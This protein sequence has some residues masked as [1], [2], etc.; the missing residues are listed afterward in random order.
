MEAPSPKRR[1][2]SP[3]SSETPEARYDP[4]RFSSSKEA[5]SGWPSYLAP[6]KAS[7]AR[8]YPHLLAQKPTSPKKRSPLRQAISKPPRWAR[9]ARDEDEII[10][11]L[12]TATSREIQFWTT[13]NRT[14]K[15]K[16]AKTAAALSPRNTTNGIASPEDGM[17]K[18]IRASPPQASEPEA[19]STAADTAN[20]S[21]LSEDHHTAS[22][23]C[24][25]AAPPS[26]PSKPSRHSPD[27][28]P[29]GEPRLPSTPIQL[30]LEP[31]LQPP[32]GLSPTTSPLKSHPRLTSLPTSSP[33]KPR[34]RRT[35]TVQ[36]FEDCCN[37]IAPLPL[38]TRSSMSGRV[39]W[40]VVP[41]PD[42]S[43][44]VELCLY[45]PDV[46]TE[47][48]YIRV[49]EVSA[50]ADE[51]LRPCLEGLVSGKDL[52]GIQGLVERYWSLA[53]ERATCWARCE[54]DLGAL[55]PASN[56]DADV[57]ELSQSIGGTEDTLHAFRGRQH[58][59]ARHDGVSLK[60]RWMIVPD[61]G[62]EGGLR[63]KFQTSLSFGGEN[64]ALSPETKE[65]EDAFLALVEGG[66]DY[67]EAIKMLVEAVFGDALGGG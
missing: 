29:D 62:S 33:L 61:P 58:F 23:T 26:T 19:Q 55:V 60:I 5:R 32:S 41:S 27:Y 3:A 13:R 6:T 45:Y 22:N 11:K 44:R 64:C 65:A 15:P 30:G 47:V 25:D 50:W 4:S 67:A 18:D 48:E 52:P 59:V 56:N 31:P 2:L 51:E 7:L 63:R 21:T 37:G 1:K 8:S 54:R 17:R 49:S 20:P 39:C 57:D 43:L 14:G 10:L 38:E 53:D 42:A 36:E 16:G 34:R 24:E 35:T 66:K 12:G 9:S 40:V 28:T 46:G